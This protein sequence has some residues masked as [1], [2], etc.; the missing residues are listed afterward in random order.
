MEI[1]L[2]ALVVVFAVLVAVLA[3]RGRAR[4][5]AF[6]EAVARAVEQQRRTAGEERPHRPR[7]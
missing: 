4:P 1:V 5:G 3:V 6:D 2:G 7:C